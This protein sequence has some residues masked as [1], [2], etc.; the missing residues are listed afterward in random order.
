MNILCILEICY[1]IKKDIILY[2]LCYS[3]ICYL[4]SIFYTNVDLNIYMEQEYIYSILSVCFKSFDWIRFTL[5]KEF[6]HSATN[7]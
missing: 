2:V 7:F 3:L 4:K 1:N 5:A 6:V